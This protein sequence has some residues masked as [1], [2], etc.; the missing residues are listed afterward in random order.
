MRRATLG[1]GGGGSWGSDEVWPED[2]DDDDCDE[3]RTQEGV[4]GTLGEDCE[5]SCEGKTCIR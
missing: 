3:R 1:E 5:G 4:G 2:G